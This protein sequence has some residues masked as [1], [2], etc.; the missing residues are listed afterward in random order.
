MNEGKGTTFLMSRGVFLADF[1]FLFS[2]LK[3]QSWEKDQ[4]HNAAE[5][6]EEVQ[7]QQQPKST[8]EPDKAK[9]EAYEKQAK[10]LL[11]GRQAWRPT[12]RALGLNYDRPT[13]PHAGKPSAG[14][15]T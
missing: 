2:S 6:Q 9:R 10:E 14:P 7:R 13:I 11:A 12:W 8:M 15:R 1:L 4:Y 5:Y 3:T